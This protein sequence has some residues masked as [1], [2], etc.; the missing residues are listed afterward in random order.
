MATDEYQE[1][2]QP[3]IPDPVLRMAPAAEYLGRS[4]GD[5]Y[6]QINKGLIKKTKLGLRSSGIRLS[7]LS[8]SLRRSKNCRTSLQSWST[9]KKLLPK[10]GKY[11]KDALAQN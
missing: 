8:D 4:V 5:L 7:E 11:R 9:R 1:V 10:S 6:R 3:A 2:I